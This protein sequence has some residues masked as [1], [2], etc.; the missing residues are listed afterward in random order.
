MAEVFDK[1]AK[2]KQKLETEV[3]KEEIEKRSLEIRWLALEYSE[4]FQKASHGMQ[5]K[6][7]HVHMCM[8]A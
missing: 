8:N 7:L 2:A 1:V 5:L 6:Y 3:V 4:L